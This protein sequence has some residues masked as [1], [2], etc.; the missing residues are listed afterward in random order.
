MKT[1]KEMAAEI[2]ASKSEYVT[3]GLSEIDIPIHDL[4]VRGHPLGHHKE[5]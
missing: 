4:P 3:Y 2:H 1:A 5:N